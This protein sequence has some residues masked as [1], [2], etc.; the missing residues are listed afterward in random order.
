MNNS[1]AVQVL[2]LLFSVS[3]FLFWLRTVAVIR[4][5]SEPIERVLWSVPAERSDDG[6]LGWGRGDVSAAIIHEA[7]SRP[8]RRLRARQ[9]R[10]ALATAVQKM[11]LLAPF[12]FWVFAL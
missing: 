4:M 10:V 8:W 6:A 11:L 1:Q 9:A 3:V 12:M 2:R 5:K 7:V